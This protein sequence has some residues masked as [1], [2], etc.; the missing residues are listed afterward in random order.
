MD[1]FGEDIVE[2][3]DEDP[4]ALSDDHDVGLNPPRESSLCLGHEEQEKFLLKLHD[5]GSLPHAMIFTGQ[6]GIGKATFAFR[7]VRFLLKN[8]VKDTAQDAL[9]GDIP[10]DRFETMD[11]SPDDPNFRK[12]LSG[13]HP[14]FR[15]FEPEEGKKSLGVELT[16]AV[17]P[18]LRSTASDGGWRVVIVDQADTMTMDAQNA[19]LK[20]LEE[21][22]PNVMLILIA[23]T[24]GQLIPTI[25]SRSRVLTFNPLSPEILTR[26]I[27]QSGYGADHATVEMLSNIIGGSAGQI[28]NA[29][30]KNSPATIQ[31]T[32]SLF[33]QADRLDSIVAHELGQFVSGRGVDGA[34]DDVA[35]TIL[36][37]VRTVL[38]SQIKK[39][40]SLPQI[41]QCPYVENRLMNLPV[42][43]MLSLIDD[44]QKIVDT[45]IYGN[46]DKYTIL[47]NMMAR[48]DRAGLNI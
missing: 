44:L 26:L 3:A 19:L 11:V 13:G 5:Q 43:S 12:I 30:E 1:L 2:D 41:L 37:T 21:P 42:H 32:L 47:L 33:V 40:S 34:F 36:W 15:Y 20:I 8:G 35:K 16:R 23:H 27:G 7:F 18:F 25:R 31:K 39:G 48:I 46:L 10:A 14:D 6:E 29:L 17:T 22:P 9:F 24:V 45:A 38:F 4:S 28:L